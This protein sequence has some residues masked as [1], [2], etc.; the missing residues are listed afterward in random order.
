M[1][2]TYRTSRTRER[3]HRNADR[4]VRWLHAHGICPIIW[5]YHTAYSMRA[6]ES[7]EKDTR[8][9]R[10]SE[11]KSHQYFTELNNTLIRSNTRAKI[12][13]IMRDVELYD[14]MVFETTRDGKRF[15][16]DVW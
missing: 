11:G 9:G 1:S 4:Y 12:S 10:S 7:F 14:D 13:K 5:T 16:W 3:H 2:R 15:I 6:R 8:D